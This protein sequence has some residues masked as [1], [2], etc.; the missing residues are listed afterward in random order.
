VLLAAVNRGLDQ[1]KWEIRLYDL[2][3]RLLSVLL[4]RHFT[5]QDLISGSEFITDLRLKW[6]THMRSLPS[7]QRPAVYQIIGTKDSFVTRR[8]SIDLEQFP[9]ATHMSVP[10]VTHNQFPLIR[11]GP[12][13]E[14]RYRFIRDAIFGH[15]VQNADR[16]P[17]FERK[18]QVVFVLHGI[19]AANRGWVQQL[20]ERIIKSL[21][22]AEVVTPGYGY[23]SA[24]EFVVPFLHRR[25]IRKFQQL[26]SDYFVQNPGAKF[27]FVGHSNGTYILG[28]SLKSLTA[29]HFD[30]VFLAGSVL[31]RDFPWRELMSG[32]PPQVNILR[33]D[34]ANS[35]WPVGFLCSGLTGLA[36]RD[37]GTGGYE[38]FLHD[39]RR[40]FQ[41]WFH[42][43]GHGAA[44][45]KANINSIAGF[46]LKGDDSSKPR[47][48]VGEK[49]GFSFLSR[50]A[51]SVF[52][53]VVLLLAGA[54]AFAAYTSSIEIALG[55]GAALVI[56]AFVLKVA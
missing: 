38:G 10:D 37:I 7:D 5:G 39:D 50:L 32:T 53:V 8:D 17:H 22:N 16:P 42:E 9:N 23:L 11:V 3:T 12:N 1:N 29:M 6:I 19:R 26:Y 27:H 51:P 34:C 56:V 36:R 2:I 46:L 35:D 25:P 44:L 28:Q 48:L 43:G 18:D 24:L 33:N 52:R 41:Y 13:P 14:M 21:P 15:K 30:R 47:N 40:V 31:P 55:V 20:D 49:R 4:F 54:F 45:E